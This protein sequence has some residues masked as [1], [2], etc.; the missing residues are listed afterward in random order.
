MSRKTAT[1][2]ARIDAE[3]KGKV[4][5]ILHDLGLSESE[6]IRVFYKQI[7]HR[8]GLP[9]DVKIPNKK[10]RQ[11]VQEVRDRKHL[12]SYD[13]DKEYFESKGF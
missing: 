2:N 12:T 9:F 10:T 4:S 11:A 8:N 3:L 13:S 1:V 6:A 5:T 7:E